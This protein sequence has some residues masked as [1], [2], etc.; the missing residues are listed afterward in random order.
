MRPT[1]LV[2]LVL[3]AACGS[4]RPTGFPPEE[5]GR[6]ADFDPLKRPLFGDTHVHTTISL[7]ANTQGTR[8][9]P[10]DAY[11]F[12]LGEEIGIQPHDAAGNAMRTVKLR[13]PLDFVAVSD[14]AEFFGTVRGCTDPGSSIYDRADCEM[15]R[16][17]PDSSFLLLNFLLG[18]EPE[19]AKYPGVCGT[20]GQLCRDL[21]D[22]VWRE[23][24]DAAEEAYDRDD[25]CN[26][27]TF[28]AYEW[29]GSP[30]T[31]NWHRNVI[32]R[33]EHVLERPI[34]YFDE[35]RPEELWRLLRED[36]IEGQERCDVLAIPHNSNLSNGTMMSGLDST[37]TPY[38]E[39]IASLQALIEPIIEIYQ[40][41]GDSE[42]L[43]ELGGPDELC[44]FEKLPYST[45]GGALFGF[46][47]EPVPA[48]YVRNILAEGVR[49]EGELGVNPFAF[50]I[51]A[52]TDTHLATPGLVNEAAFPGHGGVGDP[53]REA[54]PPGL[55]DDVTFSPGGLAGVWAEE[56]SREA[57]FL[58]MRR[59]ET[60][61]TS[62]PRI[63]IR[64]FGAWALPDG[65]CDR[66][67]RVAEAYE[68]G[69]PMGG[70]LEASGAEA[71]SFAVWAA[72]DPESEVGLERL[73]IVKITLEGD[74][75]S[76]ELFDVA[77][78][79][80][81]AATVDEQCRPVPATGG[82]AELCAVFTDPAFDPSKKTIYY[83][84][85]VENPTCRWHARACLAAGVDCDVPETITEGFEPCCDQADPPVPAYP[86]EI[87]ERA[88]TSP[89]WVEPSP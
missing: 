35:P 89:I 13:S 20:D 33:N 30:D 38:T 40:H 37:G 54:L 19:L 24:Q 27:T 88:W 34:S 53:A 73:Q 64:F 41:K 23:I 62:G 26:F 45:L 10:A 52:S 60:F 8:L 51:V 84:R 22:I 32:F 81:G 39:A 11:R 49:L 12:A 15:F 63:P 50:G 48:D 58:A 16:D 65:L 31:Q 74:D 2:T 79:D 14:H 28:V 85:A 69:V 68:A 44:G 75:T 67:D 42:C 77:G 4:E 76:V 17:S 36:C 21:G 47:N 46:T 86:R 6:C 82:E 87:R 70:T 66:V 55:V 57:I 9:G 29:S 3:L 43:P 5:L 1:L 59:K 25:T 83:A 72:A 78:D 61:G 18:N 7:D 56:N 71:P 80:T